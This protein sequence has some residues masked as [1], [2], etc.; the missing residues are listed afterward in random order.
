MK[1]LNELIK[2]SNKSVR[3]I[4]EN[5]G[6][7]VVKTKEELKKIIEEEAPLD[8]DLNYLDVSNVTDMSDMFIIV[9]LMEI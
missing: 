3:R 1:V 8:A 2:E 4:R 6:K 7:I 9:N 5:K